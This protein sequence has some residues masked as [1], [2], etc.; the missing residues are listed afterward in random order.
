MLKCQASFK[1]D[2]DFKISTS[3]RFSSKPSFHS[4]G[5]KTKMNLFIKTNY[6]TFD[7]IFFSIL[8]AVA[9]ARRYH[10]GSFN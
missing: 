9:G 7:K 2:I 10:T 5:L 3:F 8:Q 1:N 4:S 6:L